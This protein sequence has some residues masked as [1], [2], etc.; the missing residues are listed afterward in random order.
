[1]IDLKIGKVKP[2][3]Y[4]VLVELYETHAKN[5]NGDAVSEFGIILEQ[6]TSRKEQESVQ[7][8]KVIEFGP[9]A[10]S[11]LPCGSKKPEDWGVKVG[12]YILFDSYCGRKISPDPKDTRRILTDQEVRAVV[13][14]ENE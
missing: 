13:E 6:Q 8:A 2:A 7:I 5:D 4:S 9:S 10:F 11:N 12:D 14:L 3:G 1:M